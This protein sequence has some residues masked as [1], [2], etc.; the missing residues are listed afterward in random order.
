[1]NDAFGAAHRAHSSTHGITKFVKHKVRRHA[2]WRLGPDLMC[3][4]RAGRQV[5]GLLLDKEITSLTKIT[6]NPEHPVVACIGG[7]KVR[8]ADSLVVLAG[9]GGDASLRGPGRSSGVDEAAGAGVAA[10]QGGH[11]PDRGGHDVHLQQGHGKPPFPGMWRALSADRLADRGG[12]LVL[13]VLVQG[14]NIG[15]SLVEEDLVQTA[16]EFLVKA[17]KAGVKVVLPRD[18]VVA[19]DLKEENSSKAI[20]VRAPGAGVGGGMGSG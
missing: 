16:K 13:L 2:P 3:G 4:L 11:D 10:D 19:P 18:F 6:T 20:H 14:Y 7:S 15:K 8:A 1:V 12:W 9:S 5:A 17:E